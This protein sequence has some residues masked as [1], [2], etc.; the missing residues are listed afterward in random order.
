MRQTKFNVMKLKTIH[1]HTAKIKRDAEFL[2][3]YS[4][5]LAVD[6][7]SRQQNTTLQNI[8]KSIIE[9]SSEIENIINETYKK[10]EK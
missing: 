5:Y 8:A 9:R 6:R 7:I 3:K 4:G 1:R 10:L 2:K